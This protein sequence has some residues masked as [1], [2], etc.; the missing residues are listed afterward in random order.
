MSPVLLE[1]FR[2][3]EKTKKK[4]ASNKLKKGKTLI[5]EEKKKFVETYRLKLK[6]ELC[7]RFDLCGWCIYGDQCSFAHGKEE[8]VEKKIK[9][10]KFRTT[11]CKNYHE[12]GYCSYGTRCQFLHSDVLS[13]KIFFAG[14]QKFNVSNLLIEINQMILSNLSVEKVLNKIPNRTRLSVFRQLVESS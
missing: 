13:L 4:P 1:I 8:L 9:L 5:S 2:K 3:L 14:L 6:T 10:H 12:N 7:K 11:F